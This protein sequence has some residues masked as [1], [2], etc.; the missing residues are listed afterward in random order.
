MPLVLGLRHPAIR[1]YTIKGGK[2]AHQEGMRITH[3]KVEVRH[4]GTMRA[5]RGVYHPA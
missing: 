3:I 1:L 2:W 5:E 4:S